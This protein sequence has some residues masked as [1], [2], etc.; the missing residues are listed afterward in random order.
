M[1]VAVIILV[2]VSSLFTVFQ[3]KFEKGKYGTT[4]FYVVIIL[5]AITCTIL[6]I[7]DSHNQNKK[8]ED[9]SSKNIAFRKENIENQG[10]L[11]WNIEN[12]KL[13]NDNL[14][15][16]NESQRKSIDLQSELIKELQRQARNLDRL[17]NKQLHVINYTQELNNEIRTIYFRVTL[18][19]GYSFDEL[20]PFK[21]G[22]EFYS[23]GGAPFS[24][25]ELV[26]NAGF[27]K[28][29][30]NKEIPIVSYLVSDII[31]KDTSITVNKHA[32]V[33]RRTRLKNIWIP[34]LLLKGMR[35]NIKDFHD[36]RIISYFPKILID[37]MDSIGLVVNGWSILS[38][39]VKN[40]FWREVKDIKWLSLVDKEISLF[41]PITNPKGESPPSPLWRID[42]YNKLPEYHKSLSQKLISSSLSEGRVLNFH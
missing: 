8:S 25:V 18:K 36:E 1:N 6:Q 14:I 31:Q 19:R 12:L 24:F 32:E 33:E 11:N 27:M 37:K 3:S 30:G 26:T 20:C 7:F 29:S 42:V 13:S 2:W 10:R 23:L 16:I 28:V 5:I 39:S 9:E 21:F 17:G 35:G 4:L 40:V 41:Q 22:F 34:V 15:K 38:E